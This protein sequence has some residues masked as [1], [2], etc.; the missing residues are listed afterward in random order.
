MH[1]FKD[2]IN[3]RKYFLHFIRLLLPPKS[4]ILPNLGGDPYTYYNCSCS[5]VRNVA[6]RNASNIK[7]CRSSKNYNDNNNNNKTLYYKS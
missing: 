6:V 7:Q 1:C 3:N 2:I 4:P 5:T